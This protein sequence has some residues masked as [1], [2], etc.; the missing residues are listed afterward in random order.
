MTISHSK[1]LA[2]ADDGDTTHAR[3][4][5][6]NAAH[7]ITDQL[8]PILVAASNAMTFEK[9]AA[10]A[11][12]GTVCDGTHDETDF[13]AA[14]AKSAYV[15]LSSGTFTFGAN[16]TLTS[17]FKGLG[18]ATII[19]DTGYTITLNS[20]GDL[21]DLC[22]NSGTGTGDIVLLTATSS[23][24]KYR[25]QSGLL[26]GL[27]V[28]NTAGDHTRT[29]VHLLAAATT[30][31]ADISL[32]HFGRITVYG[33]EY[34]LKSNC[35][36]TGTSTSWIEDNAF[37]FIMASGCKYGIDISSTA[38][39]ENILNAFAQTLIQ[40]DAAS[41]NAIVCNDAQSHH[42]E[43]TSVQIVDW[44]GGAT[45]QSVWF[46]TGCYGCKAE[47]MLGPDAAVVDADGTNHVFNSY[48]HQNVKLFKTLCDNGLADGEGIR[49]L[50]AEGGGVVY[51]QI[52][53]QGVTTGTWTLADG[54]AE[55]TGNG[56][57][58]VALG[59]YGNGTYGNILLRGT[60][61]RRDGNNSSWGCTYY[62]SGTAGDVTETKLVGAGKIVR[63]L[64]YGLYSNRGGY[65]SPSQD[66]TVL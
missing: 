37:M 36:D 14:I 30:T 19:V 16:A 62:L 61:Y 3:P 48:S 39:N 63:R 47:G 32:S 58:G 22:V 26:D 10:L 6:W 12:G 5:D 45:A 35:T 55:S 15:A 66:Y 60:Y 9:A 54:D 24:N 53:H 64:G 42:N 17:K 1:I 8:F 50:F 2:T 38:R 40:P 46:K 56:L 29:G 25:D 59:S 44:S 31:N 21:N 11:S 43:F 52:V 18:L 20:P 34:A 27:Y 65:F 51:G 7:T 33:C 4:S 13:A 49:G 23:S 28:T 41:V 57:I